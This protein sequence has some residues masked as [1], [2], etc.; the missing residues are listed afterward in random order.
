MQ[1]TC[2]SGLCIETF[3]C[4][5]CQE[6]METFIEKCFMDG[7]KLRVNL[8]HSDLAFLMVVHLVLMRLFI[9]TL[10]VERPK[11]VKKYYLRL[12]SKDHIRSLRLQ[13]LSWHLIAYF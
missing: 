8:Y 2:D 7:L 13:I 11:Y 9:R 4:L 12:L 1:N 3:S 5:A 10:Y 6:K